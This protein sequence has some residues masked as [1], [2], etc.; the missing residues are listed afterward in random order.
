MLPSVVARELDDDPEQ[1]AVICPEIS[2]YVKAKAAF[3][4]ND[5]AQEKAWEGSELMLLVRKHTK[6]WLA[7]RAARR[8]G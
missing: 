4:S 6:E 2:Q 1:L 3:D 8:R 7:R 5:D